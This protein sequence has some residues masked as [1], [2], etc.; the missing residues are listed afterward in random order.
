MKPFRE[1]TKEGVEFRV[2]YQGLR[3]IYRLHASVEFAIGGAM[4]RGADPGSLPAPEWQINGCIR[5]GAINFENSGAHAPEKIFDPLERRGKNSGSQ[6]LLYTVAERDRFVPILCSLHDEHR[7][8]RF[9]L[10]DFR[11]WIIA[12]HN[13]RFQPRIA[14]C[15]VQFFRG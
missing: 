11:A 8:E 7:T 14:A 3:Q 10:D 5:S 2:V 12:T 4:F 1:R 13:G 6:T 15:I 9:F